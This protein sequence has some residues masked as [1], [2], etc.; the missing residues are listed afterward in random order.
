MTQPPR[1]RS[2][3]ANPRASRGRTPAGKPNPVDIH[4]GSRVR[5]RRAALGMSQ[6]RLAEALGLTFQQVQKYESGANR[7][8]ASRLWDIAQVLSVSVAHF[9]D[10]MP[11]ELKEASP[12][13]MVRAVAEPPE[14]ADPMLTTPET[15]EL[16][17][18]YYRIS[19]P[20]VR[21]KVY[22]LAKALGLAGAG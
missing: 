22:E 11:P 6:E 14:F 13:H 9:F 15:M 16:V 21:K 20:Q 3:A 7:I 2:P 5:L 1:K 18:A 10:H 4:V 8:S 12:R 19:E 17:R